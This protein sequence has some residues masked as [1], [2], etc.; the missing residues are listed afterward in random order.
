MQAHKLNSVI[1]GYYPVVIEFDYEHVQNVKL[2]HGIQSYH[3][4]NINDDGN[5][6]VHKSYNISPGKLIPKNTLDKLYK[7]VN[8]PY[9]VMNTHRSTQYHSY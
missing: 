6:S 3:D 1:E 4:L 2:W 7:D 9:L 5:V 8:P